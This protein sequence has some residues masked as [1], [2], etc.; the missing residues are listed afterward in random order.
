M[1]R[2]NRRSATLASLVMGVVALG[3]GQ[4]SQASPIAYQFQIASDAWMCGPLRPA[5]QPCPTALTGTL[6]VD[7]AQAG[8][9]NQFVDFT[10]QMGSFV[11]GRDQLSASGFASSSLSFDGGGLL[12][13][14]SFRNFFGAAP[15]SSFPIYY[16]NLSS[17]N[18]GEYRFG[19]RTDYVV[20]N[21]CTGCVSFA[22]AVPEPGALSL[23]A[24]GLGGLWITR[25]R[26][27]D[28]IQ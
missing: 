25:R 28:A 18:S 19:N 3:F 10:L 6:T 21:R 15:S 12:T 1:I 14:F 26:R 2:L 7:S 27:K 17:G 5:G 24:A 11:F 23:L 22:R 16:M 13:A 9:T 20:E 4:E 8:F